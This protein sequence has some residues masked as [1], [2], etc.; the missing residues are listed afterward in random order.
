MYFWF[1][2][3]VIDYEWNLWLYFIQQ[4]FAVTILM[5]TWHVYLQNIDQYHFRCPA[6][7]NFRA[8]QITCLNSIWLPRI[9]PGF[10]SQIWTCWAQVGYDLKASMYIPPVVSVN[11]STLNCNFG[12]LAAFCAHPNKVAWSFAII[13]RKRVNL[14]SLDQL[15]LQTRGTNQRASLHSVHTLFLHKWTS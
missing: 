12:F 8:R 3:N 15:T 10:I 14:F 5:S 7:E 9:C 11:K 2:W 13:S 4:A 1:S 6:S